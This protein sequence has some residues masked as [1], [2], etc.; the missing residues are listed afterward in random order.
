[1]TCS[2]SDHDAEILAKFEGKGFSRDKFKILESNKMLFSSMDEF[3]KEELFAEYI[4][5]EVQR[6][7]LK[8]IQSNPNMPSLS[9]R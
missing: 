1:L 9:H 7:I 2:I 4:L 3:V 6:N 8:Q 5:N